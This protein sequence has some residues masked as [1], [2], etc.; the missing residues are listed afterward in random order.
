[1]PGY[2]GAPVYPSAFCLW[3]NC[4]EQLDC[5]YGQAVPVTSKSL[6]IVLR[7]LWTPP[8]QNSHDPSVARGFRLMQ[9]VSIV[10]DRSQAE[11]IGVILLTFSTQTRHFAANSNISILRGCL[12]Q[13]SSCFLPEYLPESL[14]F[15]VVDCTLLQLHVYLQRGKF[16]LEGC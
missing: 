13:A 4:M 3:K 16:A 8:L 5:I 15:Q 11:H 10:C 6:L 1:M 9:H 7:V 12:W 2:I 14:R